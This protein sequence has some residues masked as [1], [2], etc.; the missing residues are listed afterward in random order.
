MSVVVLKI[1]W[2]FK[3]L[4]IVLGDIWEDLGRRQNIRGGLRET[5]EHQRR[6]KGRSQDIRMN[7]REEKNFASLFQNYPGLRG[8]I[9]IIFYLSGIESLVKG[10]GLIPVLGRLTSH[11]DSIYQVSS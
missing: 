7:L 4:I 5:S 9:I 2:R 1:K 8:S 11:F 6:T 10:S 3:F